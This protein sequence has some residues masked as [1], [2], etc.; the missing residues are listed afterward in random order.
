MWRPTHVQVTVQ[1]ARN[2]VRK[3]KG[4]NDAY[5]TIQLG[6]ERF[7]TRVQER[8][9]NP[10]WHEE[11]DLKITEKLM[12]SSIQFTVFHH[13]F[14]GLDEFLGHVS[15]PLS[16]CDIHEGPTNRWY[17]LQGKS[18]KEKERGELQI[19]LAFVVRSFT[20]TGSLMDL[21]TAKE[22]KSDSL[23]RLASAVGHKLQH[24]PKRTFSLKLDNLDP[25]T[26]LFRF[27]EKQ[28][29]HSSPYQ[30]KLGPRETKEAL[31]EEWTRNKQ[32]NRKDSIDEQVTK[33]E[34]EMDAP[35]VMD[36][37]D[38]SKQQS[39]LATISKSLIRPAGNR[40]S[41]EDLS[42]SSSKTET[43]NK[44][45]QGS[46][47]IQRTNSISNTTELVSTGHTD[48]LVPSQRQLSLPAPD[49]MR[50]FSSQPKTSSTDH[51]DEQYSNNTE[52]QKPSM[53]DMRRKLRITR[54]AEQRPTF[55][56][57][58]EGEHAT[59]DKPE[60]A[61]SVSE[62]SMYISYLYHQDFSSTLP[63]NETSRRYNNLNHQAS[64][65]KK[66]NLSILCHS[67]SILTIIS[68]N[69]NM[70]NLLIKTGQTSLIENFR[71]N[72]LFNNKSLNHQ[73]F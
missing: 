68:N 3:G 69:C 25:R 20:L 17:K 26:Q 4:T 21:S 47:Y 11:C 40:R 64:V 59:V 34:K 35:T 55:H 67:T 58:C 9:I 14:L 48:K 6:K 39:E 49:W 19:R 70:F 45:S 8:V 13:N 52:G 10:E 33:A 71:F 54:N 1:K 62:N 73:V 15:I 50:L 63:V 44:S 46:F 65:P 30:T 37:M 41:L 12:E 43:D 16:N 38:H 72:S 56:G 32:L 22:S 31:I 42:S 36:E 57:P 27:K 28:L 66:N 23:K 7:E 29:G 53:R 60:P 18:K 61:T 24:F 5:V 51:N 2:L